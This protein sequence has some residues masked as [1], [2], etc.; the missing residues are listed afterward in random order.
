MLLEHEFLADLF[1]CERVPLLTFFFG[2]ARK[3]A[4]TAKDLWILEE[5]NV[6][7]FGPSDEQL[8]LWLAILVII[9]VFL[10]GLPFLD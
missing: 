8:F 10:H 9:F 3:A 4:P 1:S 6:V 5:R 2:N 7:L